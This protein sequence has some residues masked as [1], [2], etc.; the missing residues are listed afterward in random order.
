MRNNGCVYHRPV[1]L[2]EDHIC[3]PHYIYRYWQACEEL[4]R[5]HVLSELQK[6]LKISMQDGGPAYI[7]ASVKQQLNVNFGDAT[8]F[9]QCDHHIS[10]T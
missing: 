2:R 8:I 6:R 3:V 10:L 7:V 5:N 9:Q 1:F 4:L